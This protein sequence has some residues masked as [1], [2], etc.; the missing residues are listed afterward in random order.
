MDRRKGGEKLSPA[1]GA[2]E[3]ESAMV[4]G[5]LVARAGGC[6]ILSGC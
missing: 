4:G 1:Q 3:D 2:E 6:S 5:R